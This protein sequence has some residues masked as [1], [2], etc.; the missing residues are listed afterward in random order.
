LFVLADPEIDALASPATEALPAIDT[1]TARRPRRGRGLVVPVDAS[2]P[3]RGAERPDAAQFARRNTALGQLRAAVRQK[4]CQADVTA[5]KLL[6]RLASRRY[7][8]VAVAAALGGLLL[9][10]IWLGLAVR[11]SST[12]RV[13]IERRLA[14]ATAGLRHDQ[15]RIDSLSAQLHQATVAA[16]QP[17]ATTTAPRARGQATQRKAPRHR[18]PHSPH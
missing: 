16:G 7:G 10:L 2:S 13:A 3:A 6:R 18:R 1:D 11:D 14:R 15:T 12:A 17:P 4:L 5:G 9:A 8:P